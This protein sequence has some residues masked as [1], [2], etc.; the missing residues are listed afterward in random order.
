MFEDRVRQSDICFKSDSSLSNFKCIHYPY[1]VV[2]SDMD[3]K[4]VNSESFWS[5]H[6]TFFGL[7]DFS[8]VVVQ[9]VM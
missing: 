4:I 5:R 6:P 7:P 8:L 2:A 1:V 3:F 9:R